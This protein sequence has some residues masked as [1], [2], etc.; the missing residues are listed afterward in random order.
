MRMLNLSV[1]AVC[2]SSALALGEPPERP[3]PPVVKATAEGVASARPDRAVIDIGVVTQAATAQA[4]G[5]QNARQ[6]T[7]VISQMKKSLPAGTQIQTAGYSLYPNYRQGPG[8]A[9][10]ITGYT[11][12]NVVKVTIDDIDSVSKAI[13]TA[14]GVGA[15]T[16][17]G[18]QFTIK[19]EQSLRGAALQMATRNARANVEAIASA[20]GT[21]IVRVVEVAEGNPQEIRPMMRAMAMNSTAATPVEAGTVDV[22]ATVMLTAEIAP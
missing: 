17:Q 5:A 21:K 2:F 22:R 7:E 16:I 11:A 14:T 10:Q 15:N 8:Q 19:D 12:S 3:R 1:L 4:A 6:T 9:Q 20:L 13:D 18:L